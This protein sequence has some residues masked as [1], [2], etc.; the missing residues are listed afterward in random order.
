MHNI[1]RGNKSRHSLRKSSIEFAVSVAQFYV[2]FRNRR[3]PRNCRKMWSRYH[4]WM[5]AIDLKIN[6]P[7]HF[8]AGDKIPLWIW[9]L[10]DCRQGSAASWAKDRYA[11]RVLICGTKCSNIDWTRQTK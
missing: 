4:T 1:F 7:C 9:A 3:V 2:Q 10:R 11:V 5:Q 8:D 6:D